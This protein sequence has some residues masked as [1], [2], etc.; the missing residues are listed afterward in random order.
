MREVKDARRQSREG[1]KEK[2]KQSIL[3]KTLGGVLEPAKGL[4]KPLLSVDDGD[5]CRLTSLVAAC[6][7]VLVEL[8]SRVVLRPGFFLDQIRSISAIKSAGSCPRSQFFQAPR[9]RMHF[10][11]FSNRM[12]QEVRRSRCLE[13]LM[14][15]RSNLGPWLP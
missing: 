13:A 8:E 10:L 9:S 12:V 3:T 5:D 4:L 14:L 2:K 1:N 15:C 11:P 6:G 7:S